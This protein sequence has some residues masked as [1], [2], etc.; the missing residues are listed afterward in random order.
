MTGSADI[1]TNLPALPN[2]AT[3]FVQWDLPSNAP[4]RLLETGSV[5]SAR[6]ATNLCFGKAERCCSTTV[7]AACTATYN[8][9]SVPQSARN[10]PECLCRGR[11][12]M[13]HHVRAPPGDHAGIH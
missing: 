5:C 4:S 1:L 3:A 6:A 10:R 7:P 9:G 12:V 11:H 13:K 8:R 2:F